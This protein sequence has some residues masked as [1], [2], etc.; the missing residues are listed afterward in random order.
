[1]N[2]GL[3]EANQIANAALHEAERCSVAISVSVCDRRGRLIAH[4]RMDKVAAESSRGSIGKAIAAV[5][6]GHATGTSPIEPTDYEPVGEVLAEG[7]PMVNR[8]GGLPLFR[9]GKLMGAIGVSAHLPTKWTNNVHVPRLPKSI[10]GKL[11]CS[12][13]RI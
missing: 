3:Q 7:V 1:M 13:N 2:L 12:P 8:K 4:Q 5:A 9:M 6:L 10:A 11:R